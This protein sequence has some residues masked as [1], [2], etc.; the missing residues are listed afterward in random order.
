MKALF[1]LIFGYR[2]K[3][4]YRWSFL[5]F[6]FFLKYVNIIV[7]LWPNGIM[8]QYMGELKTSKR[9]MLFAI[10]GYHPMD[11]WWQKEFEYSLQHFSC[12]YNIS[13]VLT[14]HKAYNSRKEVMVQIW[15]QSTSQLKQWTNKYFVSCV[16]FCLTEWYKAGSIASEF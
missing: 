2:L 15:W 11:N 3:W 5:N 16:F 7:L 12:H 9:Q 4:W 8:W 6:F 14:Q 13:V 1:K 10:W